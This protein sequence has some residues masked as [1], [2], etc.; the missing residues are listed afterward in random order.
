MQDLGIMTGADLLAQS[1]N[2]FDATF[3]Q[4]GLWVISPCA[5]IDNRPVEYQHERKSIG[6]RNILT[7][8]R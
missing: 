5:G 1:G 3:W 7:D 8:N 4:V 6:I 2:V